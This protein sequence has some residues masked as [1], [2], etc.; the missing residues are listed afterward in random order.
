MSAHSSV[1]EAQYYGSTLQRAPTEGTQSGQQ[2]QQGS[3]PGPEEMSKIA[4]TWW[5]HH[6][7][8][9]RPGIWKGLK[10]RQE[11]PQ[12]GGGKMGRGDDEAGEN[13]QPPSNPRPKKTSEDSSELPWALF[14]YLFYKWRHA[15][16]LRAL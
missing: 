6:V 13:D 9:W 3:L 1:Q 12:T 14:S 4:S 2:A 10:A 11:R 8:G 16:R 15:C 7:P 5:Q